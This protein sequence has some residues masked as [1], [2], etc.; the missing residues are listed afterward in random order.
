[1]KINS[2][3]NLFALIGHPIK[4]SLSPVM[5]NAVFKGLGINAAYLCFDMRPQN[6]DN[7][8]KGIRNLS[9]LS[10]FNVTIPYKEKIIHHLDKIYDDPGLAKTIG[11]VNTV[12]FQGGKFFG[13]NTDGAGFVQSLKRLGFNPRNKSAIVLG[14]G[15][16][17][18]ALTISLAE[19]KIS[20]L[21]IF[22]IDYKRALSLKNKIK[23]N[24]KCKVDV[25][26]N[27]K[28]L[29]MKSAQL[30]LNATPIG[31]H[32]KDALALPAKLLHKNLFVY[33]LVY[34]PE[35]RKTTLLVQAARKKG[36]DAYDGIW[37]LVFQGIKALQIWFNNKLNTKTVE[38]IIFKALAK[39]GIKIR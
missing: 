3:T 13:Y 2:S 15:G 36:L 1:M 12:K 31:M 4:H 34:N 29:D 6:F 7:A 18:K 27:I 21:Q 32:K 39:E 26:K 22:D 23:K 28:K 37:L 38:S 17:G 11:A 24:Y 35:G 25:A 33:D 16:A 14:A 20:Q 9:G 5:H 8:I 19:E 10:G 30:L